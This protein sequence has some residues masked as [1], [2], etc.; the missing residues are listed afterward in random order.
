M[1]SFDAHVSLFLNSYT[2]NHLFVGYTAI[3]FAAYVPY[4]LIMGLLFFV[5]RNKKVLFVALLA[6]LTARYAV[7]AL[8]L[9]IY[10]SSRPYVGDTDITLLIPPIVSEEYHTFPSGHALFF[11][12]MSAVIYRHDKRLG[13]FFFIA[14]ALMGIARVM[15][16]A[17]YP[18]DIIGGAVIGALVGFLFVKLFDIRIRARNSARKNSSVH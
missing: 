6:G 7:K 3:L 11:F 10:T 8:I 13:I 17:H 16:G 5:F 12:A 15:V 4:F 9:L 2:F 18:S 14:S 1:L